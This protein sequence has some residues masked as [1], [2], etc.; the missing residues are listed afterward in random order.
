MT[1]LEER[2]RWEIWQHQQNHKRDDLGGGNTVFPKMP[3]FFDSTQSSLFAVF[4]KK[5]TQLLI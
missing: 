3:E 1:Q 2:E 4:Y 5:E